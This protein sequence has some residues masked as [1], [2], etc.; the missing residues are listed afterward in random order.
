VIRRWLAIAGAAVALVA[1]PATSALAGTSHSLWDP[2]DAPT[3]TASTTA[4]RGYVFFVTTATN[5][6]G[7]AVYRVNTTSTVSVYLWQD[8][9]GTAL[10]TKQCPTPSTTGWQIC[11]FDSSVTVAPSTN[12]VIAT[13]SASAIA[14]PVMAGWC[15]NPRNSA[16]GTF[17]VPSSCGRSITTTA[18]L[19]TTASTTGFLVDPLGAEPTASTGSSTVTLDDADS[20]AIDET[21]R[22]SVWG[23]SLLV[24]GA[25]F[26]MVQV[27]PR[28]KG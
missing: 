28:M 10:A 12:Y 4:T 1:L 25:G 16:G 15:T 8:G 26:S 18:T 6:T 5:V 20:G 3:T 19:P 24:F 2:G 27:I 9:N 7:A 21:R 14:D 22:A 17:H 23:L 11:T 13:G